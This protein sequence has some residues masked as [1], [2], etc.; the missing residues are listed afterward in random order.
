MQHSTTTPMKTPFLILAAL[1]T[2]ALAAAKT[3]SLEL[4]WETPAS[5]KVPESVLLDAGR[6]VLYV[7]NIDGEPWGKD[8]RGSVGKLGLDG[9]VI[10]AEW[11]TGLEAPK[12]MALRGSKLYVGDLENVVVIDVDQG[13]VIER[14]AVPGAKG[15]NDVAVDAQ[16]VV[17]VSDTH[18]KKL[19]RIEGGKPTVLVE[20]LASPNGV[21]ID[22]GVL[23]LLDGESLYRVSQDGKRQQITDGLEGFVDGVEA[24]GDGSFIVSCWYGVIY[25]VTA[26]G[27]RQTLQDTR[28]QK[29][30][31]ADI[32]YDAN[33]R[34]VYVPTFFKNTVI[35]YRLK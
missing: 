3:P 32:G 14:I 10:A 17:Y 30:Y 12:G 11:V 31:T 7:T 35:A 13:K 1:T 4:R 16:G 27:K 9:T 28:E 21:L 22:K 15:L 19:F 6:Q 26:D 18:A 5:F 34:T 2:T 33:T 20:G 24:V 23:Y 29:L 25:H 8:G